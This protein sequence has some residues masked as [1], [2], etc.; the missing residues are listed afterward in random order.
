MPF[1]LVDI[2]NIASLHSISQ[3]QVLS[4]VNFKVL[5]SWYLSI[6]SALMILEI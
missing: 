2:N 6:G 1:L 4:F 5:L 3:E